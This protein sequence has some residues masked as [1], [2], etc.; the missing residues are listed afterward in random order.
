[1]RSR[2]VCAVAAGL[3]ALLLQ[4]TVVGPV[5]F[6]VA[7]SLPALLVII[8]GICGQISEGG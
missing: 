5:T 2:L 1:M 4:A 3:T 6:P 8:L 7:V